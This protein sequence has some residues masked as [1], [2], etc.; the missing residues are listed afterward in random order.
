MEKPVCLMFPQGWLMTA[1]GTPRTAVNTGMKKVCVREQKGAARRFSILHQMLGTG[2]MQ[3]MPV[4]W[5]SIR[6]CIRN[7]AAASGCAMM[8]MDAW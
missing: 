1:R 5:Q 3:L 2:W 8:P 7:P 4:R 6:M